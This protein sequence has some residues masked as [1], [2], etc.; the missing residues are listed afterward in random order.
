ML[1]CTGLQDLTRLPVLFQHY[2]EHKNLDSKI[3]FFGYLEEHYN[4]IP[5]TDNDEDRD[6]QLP[7]KTHELFAGNVANAITP[8]FGAIPKKAYQILPKQKILI[9]N[10]Y[11]PNSAFAGKIWQPPKAILS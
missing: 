9:N 11:I 8:S 6:N 5:H 7:F 10:D 3:T 2:F 1:S 4:D